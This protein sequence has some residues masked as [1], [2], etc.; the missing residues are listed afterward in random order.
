MVIVTL[1]GQHAQ[2]TEEGKDG[3]LTERMTVGK[4]GGQ[5]RGR[6]SAMEQAERIQVWGKERGG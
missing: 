5:E 3:R 6:V 2:D 1:S 4:K